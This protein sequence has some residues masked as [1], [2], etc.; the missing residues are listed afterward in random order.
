[1]MN[2]YLSNPEEAKEYH[3]RY[4]A[5]YLIIAVVI[6]VFS[7]RL[8]HLQIIQGS[9][10]REFSEQNRLKHEKVL[11]PRGLVFDR[12]G[13]ILVDNL[14]GFDVTITPQY[15]SNLQ[16]VA[17]DLAKLLQIDPKKVITEVRKS[18]VQNGSF[19]P[20]RVK[21]NISRDDVI[22][23]EKLRIK[24]P[25]LEV[26][27][28]IKRSYLLGPVGAQ[29]LGYV[30]EISKDEL[31]RFNKDRKAEERFEQGDIIG[32][33]G[34]EQV[35]DRDVRGIDGM[36][37]VQV[38]AHGREIAQETPSLISSFTRTTESVPGQSL[39]LTIDKDVQ[40]AAWKALAGTERIGGAIAMDPKSGEI[41]AW[42][43]A[44]SFDPSEF[45]TGI[46]AKLWSK[47][48]ND[49]YKPLRN[50][51]VQDGL[52]PGSTFKAI[53]ALAALQEKV[54]TPQTT[55]Y[56]S[57]SMRLGR[58]VYHCHLKQG[59]GN[60]N[61]TQAIE[62]SCNIFFYK[63]GMALGIDRIAKYARAFGLGSRSGI[64]VPNEVSGL[65]PDS[66]WKKKTY[67]EEWQ[68]GE[69]LSNAIGQ[70]FILATPLQMAIAYSSIASGGP[71]FKPHVLKK[72]VDVDGKVLKEIE[73]EIKM[74]TSTGLNTEV[75]IS[76]E[77]FAI[78]REGLRLVANGSHGTAVRSR[79]PGVE[80]AGK[81]GTSQLFQLTQDQVYAKCHNRPMQQRH[82]G[83]FM[84]YAPA[85]DPKIV[86]AILSEHS[87]S[88]SGGAAPVAKDIMT[89]YL[90]KY[91][92]DMIKTTA[93]AAPAVITAPLEV[94]D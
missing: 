67:G 84:G 49:P 56:C 6:S 81:T 40:E 5:L 22:K 33:S 46:S 9:E 31:P 47:L 74:D 59:H 4:K 62:R 63:M 86:V 78:V 35:L 76:P 34:L 60:V 66:E 89:A 43:V 13:Q 90:Q 23:V 28:S 26:Q 91:Y 61:I 55:H 7:L 88:G 50:K 87:C 45:S 93:K 29:L 36:R 27:V 2:D 73:P 82:H 58:K 69:S 25:G 42:V 11:A 10:L 72:I 70:G 92:P 32:K 53:V 79:I 77:V 65:I 64:L 17:E 57:G 3:S 14:P 94:E 20:V 41:L 51:I 16:E 54:A 30:G 71:V 68:A 12:N 8:W 37:F 39:V 85:T 80:V 38:D 21:D 18:R 19:R 48:I 75:K 1:M 83:W 24:H 52:P 44:P 15:V